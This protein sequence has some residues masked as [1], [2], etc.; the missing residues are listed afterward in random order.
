MFQLRIRMNLY[1]LKFQ[2]YFST[3]ERVELYLKSFT[4]TIEGWAL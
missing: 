2:K 3:V 1:I 4:D